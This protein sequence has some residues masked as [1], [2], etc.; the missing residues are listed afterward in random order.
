[1]RSWYVLMAIFIAVLAITSFLLGSIDLS[2]KNRDS[3][4]S[5]ARC[6]RVHLH[7]AKDNMPCPWLLDTITIRDKN[8]TAEGDLTSEEEPAPSGFCRSAFRRENR[9]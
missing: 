7:P 8:D 1:M 2:D 5:E 3:E 9:G 4:L 6:Y